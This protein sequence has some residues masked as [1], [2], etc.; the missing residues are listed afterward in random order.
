MIQTLARKSSG[1]CRASSAQD[2]RFKPWHNDW[3]ACSSKFEDAQ[4]GLGGSRRRRVQTRVERLL[5]F[6]DRFRQ[7]VAELL[8][9]FLGR[10]RF[11]GPRRRIDAQQLVERFAR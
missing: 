9:E 4:R 8:E 6:A 2:G 7:A 1:V 5:L 11:L 3:R 10:V